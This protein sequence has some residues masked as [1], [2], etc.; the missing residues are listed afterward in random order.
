[1]DGLIQRL[2]NDLKDDDS[3]ILIPIGYILGL[4]LGNMKP[5]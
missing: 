5:D 2:D 1:M 3:R 4:L